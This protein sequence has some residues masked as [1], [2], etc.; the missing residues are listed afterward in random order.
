MPIDVGV[1]CSTKGSRLGGIVSGLTGTLKLNNTDGQSLD[2]SSNGTFTFPSLLASGSRY[3]SP[4]SVSVVQQPSGQICSI[5]GASGIVE[6]D[7]SSVLVTCTSASQTWQ[8]GGS[9]SGLTGTLKLSNTDGQSLSTTANGAFAFANSLPNGSSYGVSVAQQPAGQICSISGASGTATTNVSNIVVTC[10]AQTWRLGAS[11][12]GLTGTLKLSNADGQSL[13]VTA[14]GNSVFPVLLA[15]GSSYNVSVAQQPS[16][17]TCSV[18]GASGTITADVS[19]AVLCQSASAAKQFLYVANNGSSNVSAYSINATTGALSIATGSPIAAGA[20]PVAAAAD[21]L[22]RFAFFANQGGGSVSAFAV[23]ATTGGLTP[24]LGSPFAAITS[25]NGLTVDPAGKYVYVANGDKGVL[26]YSIGAA[27]A[28]TPMAGSPFSAGVPSAEVGTYA[29]AVD[30]SGRFAYVA[31]A[32]F[33]ANSISAFSIGATGALTPMAGGA[34]P[35][36][37]YPN[38]LVIDAA[39]KFLYAANYVSNNVSVYAIGATGTLTQVVGSPFAAGSGPQS[40]TLASSG[41]FAYVANNGATTVSAYSI[42]PT[43]GALT[44]IAGSPFT[45]GSSPASVTSDTSGKFLYVA[46]YGS[47]N[48]S[49]FAIDSTTGGLTA[50]SGSPFAAGSKPTAL[51][52][53]SMP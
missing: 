46:N 49:A 2:I 22:G 20:G 31:N 50:V 53:S 26:A 47:N 17:Q 1:Y 43:T 16:G 25:I 19:V 35:A 4:Y 38:A 42:N 29:V 44:P 14:D 18:S 30:P 51:T 45:A 23:N 52:I 6:S 7:V 32:N 40:I 41:K 48:I 39:G 12:S 9:V 21:P 11:V 28:L 36:G 15:H 37:Q 5:S 27:G 34:T 13:T 3:G 24:V 10:A 33:M 8:V